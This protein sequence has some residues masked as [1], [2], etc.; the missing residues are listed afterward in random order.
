MAAEL[1][2]EGSTV[3]FHAI[4]RKLWRHMIQEGLLTG[5]RTSRSF[6]KEEFSVEP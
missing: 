4:A 3:P 5:K 6:L 2:D 1:L